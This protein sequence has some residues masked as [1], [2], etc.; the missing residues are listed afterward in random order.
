MSRTI[1]ITLML[2]SLVLLSGCSMRP[3]IGPAAPG[4][5]WYARSIRP[6]NQSLQMITNPGRAQRHNWHW[7][8]D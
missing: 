2:V 3:I 1:K 4:E 5:S 7:H 8:D 6:S